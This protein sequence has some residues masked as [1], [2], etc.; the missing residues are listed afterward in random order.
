M[1]IRFGDRLLT[2][3]ELNRQADGF[4]HLLA[5]RGVKAG[6][7]VAVMASNRPEFFTAMFG[8][9]KLGGSAVMI[10]PAWKQAETAHATGLTEPV[11]TITDGDTHRNR[12]DH[13][14]NRVIHLDQD[15]AVATLAH[16]PCEPFQT[17]RDWDRSEAVLV[18]S[19]GTTGLPKAVRHTHASIGAATVQWAATLGLT[20]DDRFQIATPPFHILGLLNMLASVGAGSSVRL[21]PRFDLDAVL[22]AIEADRVTLEMA[23]APIALALA[24]HPRLEEY[25]LSSLRYIM[26]GATPVTES[27]A[28]RVSERT[29]VA[30]MPAY[31]ASE[32]PVITSNPV[33]HPDRWRLDS[34]GL[35]VPDVEIRITDPRTGTALPPGETGEIQV[36]SPATMAGY[37]PD[38]A[39]AEAFSG[40]WYR[41]GD[42]GWMEPEGW[43]HI[44]DRLKEMI[45]VKGF[46]VAPAEVEAVLLTHSE[47][48][49]CAVFGVPDAESGEAVEAAVQLAGGSTATSGDL[50][51]LVAGTLAS[52]KHLRAVHM[53]DS[54]PRLP[55][56]K[57]LRRE[58]RHTLRPPTG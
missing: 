49:D 47:V 32:V 18:F 58:L 11:L 6:Q 9:L 27:V 2:Y 57:T 23:V 42:M 4:A 39:N 45:K 46:Q 48:V 20:P 40:G 25:D 16:H 54:I 10:S 14:P 17:H 50:K 56:G 41:T 38:E 15:S 21:H 55:S 19:S 34:P 5:A 30:F 52:Y 22:A 44:T 36:R 29:G 35:P 37:L 24:N 31:G 8:I 43:L 51:H 3:R 26:W 28:Q 1:A 53:V 12:P 13:S 33:H 7:R